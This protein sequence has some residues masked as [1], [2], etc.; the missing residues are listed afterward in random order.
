M[1]QNKPSLL[2]WDPIDWVEFERWANLSP[3]ARI[4][5]ARNARHRALGL[6][7]GRLHRRYPDLSTAEITWKLLAELEHGG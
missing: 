3:G 7:R 2:D 5:T 1:Q 6:M 4:F